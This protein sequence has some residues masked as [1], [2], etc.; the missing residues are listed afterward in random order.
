ML[1]VQELVMQTGYIGLGV[2]G[3]ALAR[4]LLLSRK[5]HVF[6][7]NSKV[8]AEFAA[9][10]AIAAKSPAEIAR[11]CDVIMI[12]VPRSSNVRQAIFGPIGLIEGLTPGKIV[13]DQTSGDPTETRRMAAELRAHGVIMLDAPVSGGAKGA[14][15]GT[16]AIMVGGAEDELKAVRPIFEGISPNIFHCG[17][18]GAGQ[19][20]KLIN[21]TISTCNRIAMLEGVALGLKNG[22]SLET[23]AEVLNKGGA[24]SRAT[25]NMLPAMIRGEPSAIFA[26]SL[27]LKDLNLATQLAAD[28]GAPLHF[29]QLARGLLQVASNALGPEANIDDIAKIVAAQAGATFQR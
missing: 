9:L 21:N 18:I 5:L 17:D 24:R 10:G 13:I 6:D 20:V 23:M 4:R 29:G 7:L 27:M 14:E 16:I 28:C 26:L 22:L 1:E 3:G 8:M 11:E 2:M 15:A 25:E 19:V 12:C